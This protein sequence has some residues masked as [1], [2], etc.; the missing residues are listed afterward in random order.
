MLRELARGGAAP[1]LETLDR[2]ASAL[3][4]DVQRFLD[5]IS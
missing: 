4:V 5:P 3:E 1:K 2:L